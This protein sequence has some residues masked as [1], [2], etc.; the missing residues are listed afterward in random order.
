[1]KGK[2]DVRQIT[3]RQKLTIKNGI[4]CYQYIMNYYNPDNI[5]F[6]DV[7]TEFYL[8]SQANMKKEGQQEQFFN[9]M[10]NCKL[11]TELT[12]I[13][14]QLREQPI[15]MYEFSFATKLLHT[16]NAKNGI[17]TPI[18][19]SKVRKY[20]HDVYKKTFKFNNNSNT[21]KIQA[22]RADWETLTKWYDEFKKT[23]DW[24]TWI[25]WFNKEFPYATEIKD[26][27]KIDF[28]IFACN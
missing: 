20:L 1:M 9:V 6:R 19:D 25:T 12:T 13:I 3:E 28:I 10:K 14:E 24:D 11:S 16:V 4:N 5:D 18:F 17:E 26:I 2:I 21:D 8:K 27:K 22:I 15:G 23:P 7:F